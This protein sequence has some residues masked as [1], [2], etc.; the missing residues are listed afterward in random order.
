MSHLNIN[1]QKSILRK[2]DK[3][4]YKRKNVSFMRDIKDTCPPEKCRSC[5]HRNVPPKMIELINCKICG[6]NTCAQCISSSNKCFDC[7]YASLKNN[8]NY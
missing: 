7:T 4:Q 5:G 8:C 3:Q 2:G 1:P 6:G